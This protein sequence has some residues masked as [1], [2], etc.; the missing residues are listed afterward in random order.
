MQGKKYRRHFSLFDAFVVLV[1]LTVIVVTLFTIFSPHRRTRAP[2]EYKYWFAVRSPRFERHVLGSFFE[3]ACNCH[4]YYQVRNVNSTEGD[5]LMYVRS[6]R[7]LFVNISLGLLSQPWGNGTVPEC[8]APVEFNS[9]CQL[10][11]EDTNTTPVNNMTE[12][13]VDRKLVFNEVRAEESELCQEEGNEEVLMC[14]VV[15]ESEVAQDKWS[16][17]EFEVNIGCFDTSFSDKGIRGNPGVVRDTICKESPSVM[18]TLTFDDE[19]VYSVLLSSE[20]LVLPQ[21]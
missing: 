9:S 3:S 4:V 20:T 21:S 6:S 2:L 11:D 18:I 8:F 1:S 5:I 15:M 12:Y 16:V 14:F 19:R 7:S 17:K 10:F 13:L